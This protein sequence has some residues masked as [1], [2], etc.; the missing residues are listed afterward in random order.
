MYA[1]LRQYKGMQANAIEELTR[2]HQDVESLLKKVPG[3]EMYHLL[4]TPD[5]M[6]SV[7]VC[8]DQA[9]TEESTRR[10][11]TWIKE[12]MPTFLPT[13]PEVS[14]GEVFIHAAK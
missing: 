11:A 12:Q 6:T 14:A 7:T 9:G 2:R 13:P 3:F 5:G 1:T 4:K 8:K 10:V